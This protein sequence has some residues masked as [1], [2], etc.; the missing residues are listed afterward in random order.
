MEKLKISGSDLK[1]ADETTPIPSYFLDFYTETKMLQ[2]KVLNTC[3][4]YYAC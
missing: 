4:F 3:S 1:N 2:E